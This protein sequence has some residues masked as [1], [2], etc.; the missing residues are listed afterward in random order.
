VIILVVDDIDINRRL[1]RAVLEA[2]G[3]EVREAADG[4]A[5]LAALERESFD[6]VI[7]DILMPRM[8]GYRL[9]Y[10]IRR[11][12]GLRHLPVLIYSATYTS[13]ADEKLSLDIGADKFLRKPASNA[14]IVSALR[15]LTS[16]PRRTDAEPAQPAVEMGVM[17]EYSEQLV[18]KLAEKNEELASQ[19]HVLRLSES[20]LRTLIRSEPAGVFVISAG[21]RLL[22][23]NPAGL[24][25]LE[26]VAMAQVGGRTLASFARTE[27]EQALV[28]LHADVMQGRNGSLEVE[29]EGLAGGRFWLEI[30]GACLRD[31]DGEVWSM[32][33]IAHDVTRRRHAEQSLRASEEQY[34]LLFQNSMDAIFQTQPGGEILKANTAACELFGLDEEGIRRMGREGLLGPGDGRFDALVAKLAREGKARGVIS[35]RRG[36]GSSFECEVAAARYDSGDGAIRTMVVLRDLTQVLEAERA[37]RTLEA[38]LSEAAKMEA[39]GQMASGIAHDFNN[40]VS[41]I[42]GNA[43]LA[44][45]Q[46]G[47]AA[48]TAVSLEEIEKAG[49][50]ARNMVRQLLAFASERPQERLPVALGP[51]LQEQVGLLRATLPPEIKL[52]VSLPARPVFARA[53]ATQIGEVVMNL[54]TNA[55]HAAAGVRDAAV[56]LS[57]HECDA[58]PAD[59]WPGG[60][61]QPGRHVCI[62]VADNGAGMTAGTKARIFEP[63][64]TTKPHGEGTGL[65]LPMVQGI[66]RAHQGVL[67][68]ESREGGGSVFRIF[69]PLAAA[70]EFAQPLASASAPS[71]LPRHGVGKRV[72]YLDDYEGLVFLVT[73]ALEEFGYEVQG[74]QHSGDLLAALKAAPDAFDIIVTDYNMPGASG[75]HVT[76]AIK[77]IRPDLPVLITSGL[78]TEKMQEAAQEAGAAAV[79]YKESGFEAMCA[80]IMKALKVHA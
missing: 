69:L 70:T 21:G 47:Q 20:R 57:L 62:Q 23:V 80:S 63:F 73:R 2:E 78:V 64:Y 77:A 3:V 45:R 74:F 6:L 10:E 46:P 43:A 52:E 72:A 9:C 30:H 4:L 5:A 22:E 67:A 26:A 51:I 58:P 41:A 1:L 29:L 38:R 66:V 31:D 8:D 19:A 61:P 12:E 7:S 50:L 53:N 27:H 25:M 17:K 68:V 40:I 54:C 32:L 56:A 11:S 76:R 65:G 34:R 15:E 14:A 39:I 55:W 49:V 18:A 35:A 24:D 44:R 42:L 37:R 48:A 28:R 36:D 59:L 13:P 71:S 75:V 60:I 16:R 33:A 79:I